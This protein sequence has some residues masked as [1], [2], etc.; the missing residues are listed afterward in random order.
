M[1]IVAASMAEATLKIAHWITFALGGYVTFFLTIRAS[2][3]EGSGLRL[4][5]GKGK[6]IHLVTE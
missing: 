4:P 3:F 2:L 1:L 6:L 5:Y